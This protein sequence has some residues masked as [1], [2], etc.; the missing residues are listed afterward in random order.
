MTTHERIK[1]ILLVVLI[2]GAVFMAYSTWFYDNPM[3]DGAISALLSGDVTGMGGDY[4]VQTGN[5]SEMSPMRVA[6]KNDYGRIGAENSPSAVDSIYDATRGLMAEAFN[7]QSGKWYKI[8]EE[9]WRKAIR[10]QSVLYDYQGVVRADTV[11]QWLWGGQSDV[12]DIEGRYLLLAV[13]PET[14]ETLI[15][16]KNQYTDNIYASKTLLDM[17]TVLGVIDTVSGEVISLACEL[18]GT[19]YEKLVPETFVQE[20]A[21][22]ARVVSGSNAAAY[23]TEEQVSE[24]LKSFSFTPYSVSEHVEKDGTRVYIEE[25]GTVRVESDGFATYTDSGSDSQD[26]IFVQSMSELE[27]PSEIYETAQLLVSRLASV[28]GGAGRLYPQS[29]RFFDE[30]NCWVADF[31]WSV[32]GIPVDRQSTGYAARV[33]ISDRRVIRVDFYLRIYKITERESTALNKKFAA[34]AVSGENGESELEL[35]YTDIG[36]GTLEP[37]WYRKNQE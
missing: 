14:Q 18:E 7:V 34:A 24:V 20:N 32:N 10:W 17:Q 12:G 19:D 6:V 13:D 2:V 37:G 1:T 11:T 4:A 33:V 15:I 5:M 35:R 16:I 29:F 31:G 27:S 30:Y 9:T 28:I 21:T 36:Q 8:D 25:T 22:K 23:F 3:G 26:G